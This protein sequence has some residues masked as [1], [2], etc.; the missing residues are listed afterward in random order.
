MADLALG[1]G[2]HRSEASGPYDW[3]MPSART[4]HPGTPTTGA[5]ALSDLLSAR[6]LSMRYQPIVN[7]TDGRLFAHEAL[8]RG[9][10]GTPLHEPIPLFAAAA[11]AGRVPELD[12]LAAEMAVTAFAAAGVEGRLFVNVLPHTA[13][14]HA[15]LAQ[16]LERILR[17]ADF[18]P[19]R[20]VIEITEHAENF[21]LEAMR[22]QAAALR[23]VG[24]EIAI[25]DF[26]TG[27]SGL[28]VW[29]ELRPDYVKVDRY[30]VSRVETDAVAAEMLRAMLDMAHVLGSRVVAE[31]VENGVQ[32]DV[33]RG[34]GVDF[35]QGFHIAA[36]RD[37]ATANAGDF[38][39]LAVPPLRSSAV[40]CVGDL[41]RS[42]EPVGTDARVAD[43]VALF[44]AN[45]NW[46]SIPVV[47]GGIPVGMLH[48]DALLLL[49]SRPLHPEIYNP[50]PVTQVMDARAVILDE[51]TRL[52]QASRLV[53]GR[54]DA[55]V[56]D[57]F[58]IAREG[59]YLGLGRTIQ[60]LYHI[61]EQQLLDA[62]QSNPLTLL[63]GNREIDAEIFRLLALQ[64]RFVVCHADIDHFKAYNDCYGYSLGDQVLL[65]VAGLCRAATATGIDFV[66][67]VGGDDFIFVM[68]SSD[69]ETRI[70][71]LI[72]SFFASCG[73]FYNDDHRRAGGLS[74]TDRYGVVRLF[75]LMTLSVGAVEVTPGQ[76]IGA[77]DV[78]DALSHSKQLA[79]RQRGNALVTVPLGAARRVQSAL[80][81]RS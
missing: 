55:R 10:E 50:K 26:G 40:A 15:D 36:P 41:C 34:I 35:L 65:H 39:I 43:A 44:R 19:H 64:T 60:L 16:R 54:Q 71:S 23:S 56:N 37:V 81:G 32:I 27:N 42:R 69:W 49:L 62:Q 9:P 76:G 38:G 5:D 70:A 67:H 14:V 31:G 75:P 3:G 59:L 53:T 7:A 58:I 1:R 17:G 48:R 57:E 30:F 52:S 2:S 77:V 66:G 63:P 11:A 46:D 74:T 61:T 78:T 25:D 47:H 18:D 13:M 68:R 4:S 6:R 22:R 72:D 12:L 8:L 80:A 20:L 28:K 33:L 45:R 24:C 51:R 73:R 79:K 21:E 29:S